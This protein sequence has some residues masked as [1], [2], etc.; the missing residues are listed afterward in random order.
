MTSPQYLM[1]FSR[2]G[3][4][5]LETQYFLD[6]CYD[7]KRM[8][9][10]ADTL[11]FDQYGVLDYVEHIERGVI[12][13]DEWEEGFTNYL[14]TVE[15]EEA[16]ERAANPPTAYGEIKIRPPA[17]HQHATL[18]S[19]YRVFRDRDQ[20]RAAAAWLADE[21]GEDRVSAEWFTPEEGTA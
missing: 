17:G 9:D 21:L 10:N 12:P 20:M 1:W 11:T 6:D 4:P 13:Q 14:T 3:L 15:A 19:P 5:H 7:L 16:E 8:L 18:W 2:H